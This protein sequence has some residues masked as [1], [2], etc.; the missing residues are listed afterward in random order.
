MVCHKTINRKI[1]G[2]ACQ[3]FTPYL[4]DGEALAILNLQIRNKTFYLYYIGLWV[5][6]HYSVYDEYMW[7]HDF[8]NYK[9][10]TGAIRK[11]VILSRV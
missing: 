3:L 5:P 8:Y 11:I 10:E 6:R 9:N 2:C 1:L 4:R 7:S